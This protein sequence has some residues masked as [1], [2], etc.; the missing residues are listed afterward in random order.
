MWRKEDGNPQAFP[1]VSPGPTNSTSSGRVGTSPISTQTVSPKAPACVSQGIKIK[2]D[3]TGTEDLFVDGNVEGKITLT[4]STL[5]VGP[6]AT[7]KAEIA[8]RELIVRGRAEGA[9]TTTDRMQIWHSARVHGDIRCGSIS[10]EDGA[11]LRGKVEAGKAV[12]HGTASLAAALGK[13]AESG[14]P[15]DSSTAD[16][17]ASSGATT[18]AGAD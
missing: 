2:G 17:N 12:S 5:T 18:T 1:E 14:K 7:V 4:N 6:N 9:F 16:A 3:V 11:E 13:K 15:K 10:I 8:A